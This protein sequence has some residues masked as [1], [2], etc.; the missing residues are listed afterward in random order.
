VV[1]PTDW[2]VVRVGDHCDANWGNTAI[3]KSSYVDSGVTAF[4]ASGPDGFVSWHEHN[5]DGLVLSAIGALCGKTWLAQGKWTPI[6]NTIWI[7]SKSS[8]CSTRYVYHATS[9]PEVWPSRGA[10][11]PF[12]ALGDVR[13]LK[14]LLPP[15]KEQ[16]AIAEALSDADAAIE[17]LDAL[18][19]KKRDVKQ[20]TMQQ[21]LTGR[22]R[23]PGFTVDWKKVPIGSFTDCKAGGT[24]STSVPAYWGGNIRWMSSGE[25][26]LKRVREVSGRI[27]ELGLENSSAQL[28]PADS[29]LIGLAGQGKTR[30]TA[31][32]NLVSLTTNQSIAAIFP[33]GRHDSKFLFYVMETKYKELRDLSDGGGGRG[34]LNL[35]IIK[36]V[37]VTIPEL[38][39]QKKISEVLWSIDDELEALNE[40]VL[41]LRMVKEG[42]MQ[43]LLT[44]K[45]RLV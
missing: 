21:L 43:D 17:S 29:V 20:A 19:V 38:D 27:T 41:K 42:M 30:G 16:E 9:N 40:Q 4:S 45:V 2:K 3:T 34:G 1:V 25:L 22:T 18:I 31:A 44:G 12:I 33:S 14:L 28:F 26:N 37:Q 8:N 24:P 35:A 13:V 36:D 15:L 11:Q 39:E 7:K 5:G 10:A 23:L 32:I 6:K